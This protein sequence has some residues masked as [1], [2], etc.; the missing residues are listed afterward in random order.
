MKCQY[1]HS[2]NLQDP[3]T[4]S[5]RSLW[6]YSALG[7][8]LYKPSRIITVSM[9]ALHAKKVLFNAM[10]SVGRLLSPGFLSVSGSV[11][12]PLPSTGAGEPSVYLLSLSWHHTAK[13]VLPSSSLP[14]LQ[15][16]FF[17]STS[18]PEWL[19]STQKRCTEVNRRELEVPIRE[20]HGLELLYR[21]INDPPRNKI[22]TRIA[23]PHKIGVLCLM[24]INSQLI[25]MSVSGGEISFYSAGRVCRET[26]GV[27]PQID[28]FV[29][30]KVQWFKC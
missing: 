22:R 24:R 26:G 17:L 19:I 20:M 28:Q 14:T 21:E 29:L 12:L 11:L 23:L 7:H 16:S 25:T 2:R 9:L 10:S 6:I 8:I 1:Q 3:S 5:I 13:T 15:V 18:L 27:C 4:L 30:P